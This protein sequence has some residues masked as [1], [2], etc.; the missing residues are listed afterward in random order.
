MEHYATAAQVFAAGLVFAR[1][2]AFILIMPGISETGVPPMVRLSF[3][4]LLSLCLYPIALPALPPEPAN[5]ADLFGLV[6]R[7]SLIGLM[8]GAVLRMFL[9]ALA[10]AGELVS[11]QT[12]LSFSQTANPLEAQPTTSLSTFLT[13]IGLTLIFTTNLDHYFLSALFRSYDV[14][15][16]SKALPIADAAQLAVQTAGKSFALGVQL[17]APVIV[18]ALVFNIA[19]G[20][21]GRVMPQF[22]IFFVAAPL[23]VLLGLSVFALSLGS[24]LMVWTDRY[25]DLVMLF[26]PALHGGR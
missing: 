22:Q 3:A 6:I 11:L 25:R 1:V 19:T 24:L 13:L 21:I 2:G 8:M 16:P 26:N 5:T 17:A 15:A 4:L 9:T 18:F 12:T 20:L 7:E 14:F 23:Q 10:T